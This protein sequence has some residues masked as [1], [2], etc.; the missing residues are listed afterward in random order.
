MWR[1]TTP[2]GRSPRPRSGKPSTAAIPL[3]STRPPW[4][5]RALISSGWRPLGRA[6]PGS[7]RG[8]V[9]AYDGGPLPGHV[10]DPFAD[11]VVSFNPGA[12]A[13]FGQD[14]LPGVV[15]GPPR[16]GGD[17]MGSLDVL[18]LGREGTLVL[19]F[20]DIGVV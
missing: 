11:R 8:F 5:T 3:A 12:H 4:C 20:I 18:S 14:G 13:G 17:G 16:G 9:G 2:C 10:T 7:S 1:R 19:E 15:L 6:W